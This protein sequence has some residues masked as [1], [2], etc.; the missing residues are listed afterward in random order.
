MPKKL[1]GIPGWI[2]GDSTFGVSKSYLAYIERFGKVLI[3]TPGHDEVE[4]VDLLILPGGKDVNPISYNAVPSYWTGDPNV[5]LEYFDNV[6]LPQYMEANIP[7]LGICRGAQALWAHAGGVMIQHNPGHKQSSW[8]GD[9]C[10]GLEYL[11][12]FKEWKKK[13]ERVNSRHHQTMSAMVEESIPAQ[14]EVIAYALEGK[15]YYPD[16]VELFRFR[17][18]NIFGIQGHPEDMAE[19]KLI[20]E[21]INEYLNP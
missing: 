7:I 12:P 6:M 1:I 13:L 17:N 2:L 11:P 4:Q 16:I 10:H 5:M 15:Y 14:I 20:P 9:Q 21:I 18:R 19:D 3:L 8:N